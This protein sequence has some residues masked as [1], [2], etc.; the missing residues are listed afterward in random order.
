VLFYSYTYQRFEPRAGNRRRRAL[1]NGA[2]FG[3]LAVVLMTARIEIADGIY[4]DART[5]PIALIALFEGWP[6][7]VIAATMPAAYRAW[8][9]GSGAWAGV[10]SLGA[11]AA[12]GGLAQTWAR[13][14][15]GV[16]P[17]HALTLSVVVFL[18][19]FVSFA[20]LGARGLDLFGQVWFPLLAVFIVGIGFV[21]RLF[22][23]VVERTE[24]ADAHARFRGIIDEASDA[25]RIVDPDTF[26]ILDVNRRDCEISGYSREA[27]I[28]RD[29][30]H[31]WPDQ[32]ELQAPREATTAEAQ[33][34]SFARAFGTAYR[35]A[36]GETIRVDATRRI[37]DHHGRHYEIV[38]YRESAEREA[39]EAARR[40]ATDLRAVALLASAAAH[41]IN[42]P[43]TV[44]VGSLELLSRHLAP[45]HQERRWL[46]RA[47][48]A[49]QRIRDIVARMARITRIERTDAGPGLPPMLDIQKSSDVE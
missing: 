16:G 10:L 28:G 26:K 2:V 9:G 17:R 34:H 49:A 18:T 41:E 35:R 39:A 4:V 30:R 14:D 31:F 42:N 33:T 25:I 46:E 29:V 3:G 40:E 15:G 43:L 23:D 38:I 12:A 48:A 1:L 32:P 47:S 20:L 22:H 44:V 11:A 7:A 6:T 13:R 37:V 24:A 36:S 45:D 5:V 21:A 19:T 8:L 27:L